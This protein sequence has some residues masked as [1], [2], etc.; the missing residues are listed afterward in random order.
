[1]TPH[2]GQGARR[3]LED[4]V[5]LA[6]AVA[7]EPSVP[8]APLGSERRPRSQSAALAAR[9]ASRTGRQLGDPVAV[10]LRNTAI[11]LAPSRA[12][13]RTILRHAHW[14]PPQLA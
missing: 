10:A 2:L 14:T 8:Q 12:T 5:S 11:R 1:M 9:R 4:A 6:A 3:A 13:I 7:Q